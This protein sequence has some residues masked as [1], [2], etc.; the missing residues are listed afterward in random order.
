MDSLPSCEKGRKCVIMFS[1]YGKC[2]ASGKLERIRQTCCS[3]MSCRRI[4][5]PKGATANAYIAMYI[6]ICFACCTP[7]ILHVHIHI[8]RH[9]L[10]SCGL[11]CASQL[12]YARK[13]FQ[14][15]SDRTVISNVSL[16]MD[17]YMHRTGWIS[18]YLT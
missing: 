18:R 3:L 14:L 15:G 6:Y 11:V 9:Q 8:C 7:E 4:K 2:S 1:R 17:G 5:D 12:R 16:L 10:R 13:S